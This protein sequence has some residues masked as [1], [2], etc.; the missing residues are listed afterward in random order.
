MGHLGPTL[1]NSSFSQ[2][3]DFTNAHPP[4][5]PCIYHHEGV[6]IHAQGGLPLTFLEL[7]TLEWEAGLC[8]LLRGYLSLPSSHCTL[9]PRPHSTG[10]QSLPKSKPGQGAPWEI[11][12]M[13]FPLSSHFPPPRSAPHNKIPKH[14]QFR[15]KHQLSW[16]S[17]L[18]DTCPGRSA[19][20][21]L[22]QQPNCELQIRLSSS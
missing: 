2:Y 9:S 20:L 6:P 14:T 8:F 18:A 4:S 21:Q 7:P 1:W 12:A 5:C 3:L 19:I 10:V 13:F 22:H 17:T 15:P 11:G 16:T